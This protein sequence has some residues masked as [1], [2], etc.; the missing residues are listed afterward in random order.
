MT[1]GTDFILDALVREGIDHLFM[2]PGGWSIP[3]FPCSPVIPSYRTPIV[4]AH[5]GGA[6]YMADGYARANGRFGAVL[7]IGGPGLCNVTTTVAAAKT[8]SRR[9][10]CSAAKS[11]S[12]WRGSANSRMQ[13]RHRR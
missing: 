7:G 3:F 6:A 12:T 11:R 4:A 13:S 10:W 9:S 2:V 1:A 8:N 5:E